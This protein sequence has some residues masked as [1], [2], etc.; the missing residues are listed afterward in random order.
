VDGG[1]GCLVDV[2]Q[3]L[4]VVVVVVIVMEFECE[5]DSDG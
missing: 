4:W 5:C 1:G 2:V 3:G